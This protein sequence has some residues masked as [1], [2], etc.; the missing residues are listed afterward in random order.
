M[1]ANTILPHNKSFV[2]KIKA[3]LKIKQESM[4]SDNNAQN[5]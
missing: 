3:V 4:Q 1:K 5:L 2:G